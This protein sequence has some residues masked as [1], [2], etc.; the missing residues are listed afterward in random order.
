MSIGFEIPGE[1][2]IKAC[3]NKNAEILMFLIDH[4]AP[5]QNSKF[6]SMSV[7]FSPNTYE[8]E[9]LIIIFFYEKYCWNSYDF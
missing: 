5:L 8:L 6:V 2:S 3:Q 7:L 9:D 4:N 1:C